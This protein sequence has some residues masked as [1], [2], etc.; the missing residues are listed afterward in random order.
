M[1][2]RR[3]ATKGPLLRRLLCAALAVLSLALVLPSAQALPARE[4]AGV[5]IHPWRMENPTESSARSPISQAAGVRWARVDLRWL[6]H[7]APGS[8]SGLGPGRL[9]RDGRDRGR[10]AS[11]R[12]TAAPHRRLRPSLGHRRGETGGLSR[13]PAFRGLLRGRPAPLSR[14]SRPGSSGTSPTSVSSP[15][16]GPIRPDSLPSFAARIGCA[17]RWAPAPS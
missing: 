16:R 15:S 2:P 11:S 8:V 9:E 17:H 12:H 1:R 13:R 5:A 14:T 7:R 4:I 10:R 6:A 3:L